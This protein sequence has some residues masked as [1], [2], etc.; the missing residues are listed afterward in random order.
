MVDC[1]SRI[2]KAVQSL[3]LF[4][5]INKFDAD[6][7]VG[8]QFD[9]MSGLSFFFFFFF[10]FLRSNKLLGRVGEHH[11]GGEWQNAGLM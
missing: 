6:N 1:S 4:K 8:E 10:P 9:T 11:R 7:S 2:S 3:L 5:S